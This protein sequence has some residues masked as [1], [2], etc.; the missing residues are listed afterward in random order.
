MKNIIRV[1]NL[2]FSYSNNI[3][4][5]NLNE[6]W[7]L[8]NINFSID[9]GEFIV[10]SG[11]NGSGKSTLLRLID[12]LVLPTKGNIYIFGKNTSTIKNLYELRTKIGFVFQNPKQ[13]MITSTVLDEI[14]FGPENLGLSRIEI[15][16]RLNYSVEATDIRGLLNRRTDELSG[17]QRQLVAIAS[18]LA[19]KPHIVLFDEPTSMLHP[20]YHDRIIKIIKHLNESGKTVIL[21][22]HNA[23]D[24][25]LGDRCFV[26]I[27][28]NLIYDSTPE[29]L[30]NNFQDIIE[31]SGLDVPIAVRLSR[32]VKEIFNEIPICMDLKVLSDNIVKYIGQ[33]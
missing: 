11:A 31:K 5:R 10:I 26:M 19:M 21:V 27:D 29:N 13:Q 1:E 25:L 32:K 4:I 14:V 18:V 17:G 24:L 8:K 28:G 15:E 20:E 6:K 3:D 23:D 33:N 12:L 30:F 22:T 9:E 16:K 2:F 7:V